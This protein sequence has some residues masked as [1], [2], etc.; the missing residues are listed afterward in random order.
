MKCPKCGYFGPDSLNTCKKCGKELFA[1][2]AKLGLSSSK[3]RSFKPRP[4]PQRQPAPPSLIPKVP[5]SAYPLQEK[6]SPLFTNE[7]PELLIASFSVEPKIKKQDFPT[8]PFEVKVEA[9]K[10]RLHGTLETAFS[11]ETKHGDTL[12]LATLGDD[13]QD[14]KM[15]PNDVEDFEFPEDL[16]KTPPPLSALSSNE[17]LFLPDEQEQEKIDLSIDDVSPNE[18]DEKKEGEQALLSSEEREKILR[19]KNSLQDQAPRKTPPGRIQTEPLDDEEIAQILE[20][21]N[22]GPSEPGTTT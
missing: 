10:K 11:F 15:S 21:I 13:T 3:N 20:D 22:H 4:I 19:M 16:T 18:K 5:I 9:Q 12:P 14:S 2:K 17:E 6:T 7:P 1:E 8:E